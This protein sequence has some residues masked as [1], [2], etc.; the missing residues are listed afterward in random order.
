[1]RQHATLSLCLGLLALL[2]GTDH[3][4][5]SAEGAA[6]LVRGRGPSTQPLSRASRGPTHA[7]L[8]EAH[9]AAKLAARLA[10]ANTWSEYKGTHA[11][12]L[13]RVEETG[14]LGDDRFL[15]CVFQTMLGWGNRVTPIFTA[16]IIALL[17]NRTLLVRT[18]TE[19]DVWSD[20]LPVWDYLEPQLSLKVSAPLAA[21]LD[22]A[23]TT[24]WL[25]FWSGL[26]LLPGVTTLN[27]TGPEMRE[28]SHLGS[29]QGPTFVA[30]TLRRT[31]PMRQRTTLSICLG[32]LALLGGT[33]HGR[34]SA[35]GPA[36]LL[37]GRGPSNQPLSRASRGPTHATLAEAHAASKL[38]ARL[39]WANTWS[40][41]KEN[42]AAT[43]RRV[44][45]TGS[46]GEDRFLVCVFQSMLGWG[47]RVTP[48][49]TAAIIALLTNRMLLVRMATERD[50]WS[51]ELPV[52]DYL[53]PQPHRLIRASGAVIKAEAYTK[54]NGFA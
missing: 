33:D 53:E 38:A 8:A 11:A 43:L 7:A 21:L 22:S 31:A 40:E 37:R 45:E 5:V 16:A 28:G 27:W 44:K 26:E 2:S 24:K 39:A 15:V 47:N 29:E 41:Y 3:G 51:D 10:W 12:T 34:A 13:R 54:S 9:A 46:L 50:V 1:M 49:F 23:P 30:T 48:I 19:R 14:S 20:E 32:L 36:V 35:E 6:V 42:H 17:T 52:W 4:R 18:A 25:S